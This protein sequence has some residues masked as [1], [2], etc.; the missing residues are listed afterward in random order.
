MHSS[1]L[2]TVTMDKDSCWGSNKP[3]F[4]AI[5]HSR[6]SLHCVVVTFHNSIIL[7]THTVDFQL[8]SEWMK[9]HASLPW[10]C[11]ICLATKNK[12][13]Y[14]N[15]TREFFRNPDLTFPR[16]RWVL[17][18]PAC[19]HWSNFRSAHQVLIRTIAGGQDA[20]FNWLYSVCSV[21]VVYVRWI[22]CS[23][24]VNPQISS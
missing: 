7:Q 20:V 23:R 18:Q 6:E 8:T 14:E 5:Q 2:V 11:Y 17:M 9:P 10:C 1:C 13:V 19:N 22:C 21:L 4:R 12:I 15:M 3:G 16:A 24:V